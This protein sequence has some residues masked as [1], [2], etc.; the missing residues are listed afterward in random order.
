MWK[1]ISASIWLVDI[2][3]KNYKGEAVYALSDFIDKW[4]ILIGVITNQ[5]KED[6]HP[7]WGRV[8]QHFIIT[9]EST[10]PNFT[11]KNNTKAEIGIHKK[12]VRYI[13]QQFKVLEV[14][15]Y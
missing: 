15:W 10:E 8:H 7:D 6:T 9:Q 11:W 13:K 4:R 3:P 5:E 14:V 1:T 12:W 2:L